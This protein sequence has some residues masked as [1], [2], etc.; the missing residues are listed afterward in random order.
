MGRR[1][2]S[3]NKPKD[4]TM[5]PTKTAERTETVADQPDSKGQ[6]AVFAPLRLPYDKRINDSYGIGLAQWKVLSEAIFPAAKTVDAIVMALAYCK[7][8][9]LDIMK[10]PVHIVPM[11][12]SSRGA[13]VETVWPGISELRTTASRTG[14]YAGCDEPTFGKNV[15][16]TFKGR[17]KRNGQWV[18]ET[19][20]VEFP[21]YCRLTVYKIVQGQRVAF[22]GPKVSWLETYATQ[23]N[24]ELPNKMWQ[25][26]PEGQLEK[27]AE[28]AAL[29]RAFPEETGGELTAEEMTGKAM[30]DLPTEIPHVAEQTTSAAAR[31]TAPP[32]QTKPEATEVKDGA[33][34]P[35]ETDAAP[36]RQAAPKKDDPI[37]TGPQRATAAAKT[38]AQE[39]QPHRIPGE[40]HTFESWAQ[41]YCDLIRTSADISILYKW[42]DENSRSFVLPND[43]EKRQQTGPLERLQKGK[44]SV[45]ATVKKAF[46][47][48]L[49]RLRAAHPKQSIADRVAAGKAAA[50]APASDM[51]DA[52][53]TDMADGTEPGER[54]EMMGERSD[55][56]EPESDNPE[57]V[58]KWIEKTLASIDAAEDLEVIWENECQSYTVDMIPPD[59]DEATAI[60]NRHK[61]RLEP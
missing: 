15:K 33:A 38:A 54:E 8:R 44:P 9:S 59:Q 48:T 53:P 52:P 46:E 47:E 12:D 19:A 39:I 5:S 7:A 42:V 50:A 4:D 37:S 61:K 55:F 31:D 2:G 20:E 32:R 6:V 21:E 17:V 26:R 49:D 36:P 3:K 40:G 34:P 14:V 28:A 27:C 25:E 45:Y 24:T 41:R 13:Y 35:R 16:H 18:E 56:G 10:R 43:P 51:D 22:V 11:W 57:H 1:P 60:Y 58:L 29:R 30:H 23:G